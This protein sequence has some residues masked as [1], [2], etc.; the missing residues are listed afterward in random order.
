MSIHID[1]LVT[2]VYSFIEIEI[3]IEIE[4]NV[5]LTRL[6]YL[7]LYC[8]MMIHLHRYLST[9]RQCLKTDRLLLE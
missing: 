6:T 7:A 3:E 4:Y 8:L 5:Y 9:Y 1:H 2:K